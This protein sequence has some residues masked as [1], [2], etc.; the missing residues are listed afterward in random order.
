MLNS[1]V[2]LSVLV[3]HSAC[4]SLVS[5][6]YWFNED[7]PNYQ[8]TDGRWFYCDEK[9]LSMENLVEGKDFVVIVFS[10]L[11]KKT[12]SACYVKAGDSY[13]LWS[14]MLDN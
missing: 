6:K 5:H 11:F 3:W 14:K 9:C 10:A 13:T 8:G 2:V 7:H 1:A 4:L 12:F